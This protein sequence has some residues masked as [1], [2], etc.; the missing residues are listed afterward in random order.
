MSRTLD[1]QL[2]LGIGLTSHLWTSLSPT[3]SATI[4]TFMPE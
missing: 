1:L 3:V 4:G 2:H